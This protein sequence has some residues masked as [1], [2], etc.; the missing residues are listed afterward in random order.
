MESA[1]SSKMSGT[2]YQLKW[3]H[4][5][6]DISLI[7]TSAIILDLHWFVSCCETSNIYILTIIRILD[8]NQCCVYSTYNR[9]DWNVVYKEN[10][11]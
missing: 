3:D 6:Q 9:C 1:S 4:S 2:I 8:I 10:C 11:V 7:N 5:L